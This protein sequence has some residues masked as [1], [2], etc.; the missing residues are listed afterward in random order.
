MNKPTYELDAQGNLVEKGRAGSLDADDAAKEVTPQMARRFL[1]TLAFA[2]IWGVALLV[3]SAFAFM[4]EQRTLLLAI[5]AAYA[6]FGAGVFLY[7]RR[8][9]NSQ[10]KRPY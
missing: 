9:V 2:E 3:F 6:L 4:P 1:F 5:S 8:H 7:M 10:V